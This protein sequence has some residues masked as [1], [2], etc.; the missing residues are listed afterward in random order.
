MET[1]LI[2]RQLRKQKKWTQ[3]ELADKLGV[4]KQSISKYEDGK[5][6]VSM[7][8]ITLLA[9]LFSVDP[10]YFIREE[11]TSNSKIDSSLMERMFTE[12]QEEIKFLRS[13]L[14]KKDSVIESLLGKSKTI[15]LD[16]RQLA[17]CG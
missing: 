16:A 1:G 5:L 2:I 7:D 4:T 11:A 3:E 9:E 17:N 15:Q 6:P 14:Q 13:Q 12:F 8:K 10:S